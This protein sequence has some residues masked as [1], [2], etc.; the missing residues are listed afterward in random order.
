MTWGYR[1]IYATEHRSS[2]NIDGRDKQTNWKSTLGG[3]VV[4]SAEGRRCQV[5]VNSGSIVRRNGGRKER[6]TFLERLR[7]GQEHG[8]RTVCLSPNPGCR[9]S[10]AI[11]LL[12]NDP[13]H[14]AHHSTR[15][16]LVTCVR[17]RSCRIRPR[18]LS[19]SKPRLSAGVGRCHP[20]PVCRLCWCQSLFLFLLRFNNNN[21]NTDGNERRTYCC[22]HSHT[23]FESVGRW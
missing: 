14:T 12:D 3:D 11:N 4:W 20:Y 2:I 6:R 1:V 7:C 22:L 13:R 16:H 17:R 23:R 18:L 21:S 15:P 9:Q 10:S 19:D 5:P 8:A